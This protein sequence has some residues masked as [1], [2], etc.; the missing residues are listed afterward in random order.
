MY[1]A[2][3]G[4]DVKRQSEDELWDAGEEAEQESFGAGFGGFDAGATVGGKVARNEKFASFA[5]AIVETEE[6]EADGNED[7][8]HDPSKNVAVYG[9]G[10]E[11][12]G[13]ENGVDGKE[14]HNDG[15]FG[16]ENEKDGE[17]GSFEFEKLTEFVMRKKDKNAGNELQKGHDKHR[18]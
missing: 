6:E 4:E 10:D 15:S 9:E 13:V 11:G 16:A 14:E 7:A 2:G 8:G 17:V 1:N 18:Q 5:A 3:D 12:R